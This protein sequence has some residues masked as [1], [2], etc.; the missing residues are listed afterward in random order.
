MG[1]KSFFISIIIIVLLAASK[2]NNIFSFEGK[3]ESNLFEP[4]NII[5]TGS[6]PIYVQDNIYFSV[7]RGS[8]FFGKNCRSFTIQ[9]YSN[10]TN[11]GAIGEYQLNSNCESFHS[12]YLN[13]SLLYLLLE[14]TE[15][16]YST[17]FEI[18]DISNI[19]SPEFK[20][21]FITNDS[22]IWWHDPRENGHEILQFKEDYV[23][24]CNGPK[25]DYMK[26]IRI[27]DCSNLTAPKE[28]GKYESTSDRILSF[29][30]FEEVMYVLTFDGF[31]DIVN[32]TDVSNPNLISSFEVGDYWTIEHHNNYLFLY[33]SFENT[34]RIYNVV[35]R[36]N[37]QY[38]S[39]FLNDTQLFISDLVFI[40]NQTF[41]VSGD[42][43][44]LYDFTNI[45]D[46]TLINSHN[47]T[48]L[49][50]GAN[51]GMG[52]FFW[53][54]IDNNRLYLSRIS[55]DEG[56]TIFIVDFSDINNFDIYT[57][58][59]DPNTRTT[60]LFSIDLIAAILIF[61]NCFAISLLVKKLTTKKRYQIKLEEK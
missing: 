59:F 17:G 18:V 30:T 50:S 44:G 14:F 2:Y 45:Y 51:E 49:L 21:N 3:T 9:D 32:I 47:F 1:K 26:W 22:Y 8:S 19:T 24:L 31:I 60:E 38:V 25:R 61:T 54:I 20:G 55:D 13:D 23:F 41:V 40:E 53:G 33:K 39:D 58:Y 27:I 11:P 48:E 34:D 56:L 29:L 46:I 43:V 15:P 12:F 52:Q 7:E 4:N 5:L 42:F 16:I 57:P 37:P 10:I 6:L 36:T 28:I 35:N